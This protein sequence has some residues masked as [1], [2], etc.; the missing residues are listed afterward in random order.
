MPCR[1]ELLARIEHSEC[2]DLWARCGI[3]R[4]SAQL[5]DG[6]WSAMMMR[7]L[8]GIGDAAPLLCSSCTP[9]DLY[10]AQMCIDDTSGTINGTPV[11]TVTSDSPQ[12]APTPTPAPAA[13]VSAPA[14]GIAPGSACY[15]ASHDGGIIHC[16]GASD[17]LL[18]ALNP[19]SQHMTTA[20][21]PAEEACFQTASP[22]VLNQNPTLDFCGKNIGIN[23]STLFGIG[24][25][26]VAAVLILRAIK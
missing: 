26:A 2:L 8:S 3:R 16:A 10:C 1:A 7:T 19:F 24:L 23:C 17:V 18:S 22:D 6:G 4:A 5:H 15:D 13:T 9:G 14:G 25:V 11:A 12:P 21:S 20:C